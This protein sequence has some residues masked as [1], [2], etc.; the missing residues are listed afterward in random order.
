[1]VPRRPPFPRQPLADATAAAPIGGPLASGLIPQAGAAGGLLS[2]MMPDSAPAGAPAMA[3]MQPPGLLPQMGQTAPSDPSEPVPNVT[4]EEQAQYDDFVENGMLL[5]FAPE[6]NS[7]M[8]EAMSAQ[9]DP[10]EALAQALVPVVIRLA[11]SALA[12]GVAVS[13]DVMM[14]GSVEL[15][16]QL[17]EWAE[18][19]GLVAVDEGVL[20]A[21]TYR[22]LDLYREQG[23]QM[24]LIDEEAVAEDYGELEALSGAGQLE[25]AL[26]ELGGLV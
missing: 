19:E 12:E 5:L 8:R 6:T 15:L 26:P 25:A 4:P 14:Q 13:G 16:E 21:A 9:A 1:M 18:A 3:S 23:G 24:G 7:A 11:E 20:E 17:A 22:A 10:V 2:G